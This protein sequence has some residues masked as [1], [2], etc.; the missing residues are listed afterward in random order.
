[1]TG[2]ISVSLTAASYGLKSLSVAAAMPSALQHFTVRPLSAVIGPHDRNYISFGG[3]KRALWWKEKPPKEISLAVR[4]NY[5]RNATLR[6]QFSY[7]RKYR[8]RPQ[9]TFKNVVLSF[10]LDFNLLN[11][12]IFVRKKPWIQRTCSSP[13]YLNSSLRTQW[14]P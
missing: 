7:G 10:S 8:L 4:A 5:G 12:K 11:Q 9:T 3:C 1:M 6:L 13:H 2:R 14:I